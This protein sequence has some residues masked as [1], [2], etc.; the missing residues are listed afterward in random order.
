MVYGIVKQSGGHVE[1]ESAPGRGAA[2]RVYLPATGAAGALER[3][4]AAGA[5]PRG[6]ETVLVVE[7]AEGARGLAELA[8]RHLGYTVLSAA[9]AEQAESLARETGRI[10][11]L[12]TD[13]ATVAGGRGLAERL[14]AG[15]P[16]L[17]VLYTTTRQAAEHEEAG[18]LHKPFAPAAL[19]RKVREALDRQE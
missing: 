3:P 12:I 8:L 15:Q 6:A 9:G 13:A 14:R 17:R 2:F 10:D 11:L 7:D 19:A 16:G 5:L 18:L 4:P 1:V